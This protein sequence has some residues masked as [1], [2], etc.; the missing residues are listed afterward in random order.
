MTKMSRAL[1]LALIPGLAMASTPFEWKG[2]FSTAGNT[3]K[4]GAQK[5]GGVYVDPSM[6]LAAIP[7]SVATEQS[8]SDATAN[9]TAALL[10]TCENVQSQGTITPMVNKCYTLVFDQSSSDSTYT[11]DATNVNAIAF[12]AEHVPTEFEDTEHYFKDASD[13]DIE[14]Q[15]QDPSGAHAHGHGGGADPF[16]G[17]CIC[18]AQTHNW[19]LDCTDTAYIQAEVD[20]LKSNPLCNQSNPP[21][22]CSD[23]YHV[24]QA[25]HDHC[26][27]NQLPSGIEITLHDYEHYYTDCF[28]KRQYDPSLG[29]CPAVTCSDSQALTTAADTL[30]AG[31]TTSLA[32]QANSCSDAIKTVLM[33][34]DTCAE[35]QLP[36]SIEKALHDHEEPCEAQLCNT[37]EAAFDPYATACS[38]EAN[39]ASGF[40]SLE[41]FL[42]KTLA[43]PLAMFVSS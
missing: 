3:Y 43:L 12:F 21:D 13:V 31:C 10:T 35:D 33:S 37:A 6:K 20:K 36:D 28:I 32:C 30:A 15:A 14:P 19:K 29:P 2:V 4:W 1:T 25:H 42:V 34:H 26:L 23:S 9:G 40:G 38:A 39:A 11:V 7:V 8:L 41:T 22:E 27:H 24:M 5:V 16:A 18:Q 17:L